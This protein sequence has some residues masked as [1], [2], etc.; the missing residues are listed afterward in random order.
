MSFCLRRVRRCISIAFV[1]TFLPALAEAQ[2]TLQVVADLSTIG[3]AG[4]THSFL[5]GLVRG[6]DGALYGTVHQDHLAVGC[7]FIYRLA[8]DHT[9]SVLHDLTYV[10]GCFPIGDLTVGPDGQL[11]G[12]AATGGDEGVGTVF[13]V[14]LDGA[15]T[16]VRSFSVSEVAGV[17]PRA[18]LLLG[19]DGNFYGTTGGELGSHPGAGAVFRISPT[20]SFQQLAT[21][22]DSRAALVVGPDGRLYGTG[23]D[24][25]GRSNVFAVSMASVGVTV[26]HTFPAVET[27]PNPT[28]YPEGSSLEGELV[29]GP[30]GH[31]YG[32]ARVGGPQA[33]D[34]GTIFRITT[35]G[36]VSVLKAFEQ[37][38]GSYQFGAAPF[39]G[40]TLGSDGLL[41]GIASAG[42]FQAGVFYR[43]N[44]ANGV[45]SALLLIQSCC[46]TQEARPFESS[47]GVFYYPGALG[48]IYRVTLTS[49]GTPSV[50]DGS[51]TTPPR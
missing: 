3:G 27:P 21:E 23:R 34:E 25:E 22:V 9:L 51:L 48:E 17:G 37:G 10:E 36:V 26:L 31:L 45:Y 1:L 24:A 19:P 44:P 33:S 12:T 43:V 39:A 42:G 50:Q 7:G 30:D 20:G 32:T 18:G 4:G 29:Q 40:M 15:F 6:A 13:K 28:I 46:A 14:A 47:P 35:S 5:G 49:G 2:A 11:W 41:Y 38:D 16:R 8:P